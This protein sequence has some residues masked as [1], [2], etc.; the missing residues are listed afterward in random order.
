MAN[1]QPAD[2]HLRVAHCINEAIMLRDFT[3]RQRKI[4]DLILRLS[5][6]CGKKVATIPRQ[7]DFEVVGVGEGHVKH[8]LTWLI[9]S[10]VILTNGTNY[11]FNKDYDQWQV[12]RVKPYTPKKLTE[13]VS[14]NLKHTYQNG[15][16]SDKELTETVSQNLPK[17]EVSTYQN[18]KFPKAKLASPKESI[19]ENT[20]TKTQTFDEYVIQLKNE[21]TDVDFDSELRKFELYWQEGN[22]KLK[23]PKLALLNWMQKARNYQSEK[24]VKPHGTNKPTRRGVPGNRP[25][26]VFAD[27]AARDQEL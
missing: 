12:S 21:F 14:L 15:K 27:L 20:T 6:G 13:L 18:R 26:G 25:V 7:R 5:W 2:A 16:L 23:R 22:R 17:Q 19:K 3:K 4:L 10:K 24:G 8:E 11:A 1:P 9:E